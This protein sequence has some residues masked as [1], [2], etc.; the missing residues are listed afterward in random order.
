MKKK[1][2][3]PPHKKDKRDALSKAN[4]ALKKTENVYTPLSIKRKLKKKKEN[5]S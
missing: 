4:S 1:A 2:I 5:K 3:P